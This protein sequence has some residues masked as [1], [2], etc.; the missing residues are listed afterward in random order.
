M[1]K[2]G[3]KRGRQSLVRLLYGVICI[4]LLVT[5]CSGGLI[6]YFNNEV[7]TQTNTLDEVADFQQSY[8]D[9]LSNI[10]EVSSL[11]LQLVSTGYRENQVSRMESLLVNSAEEVEGLRQRASDR[12]GIDHY[13][14]TIESAINAYSIQ[15]ET[16]FSS[17]FV[18]D[19]IEQIRTRIVPVVTRTEEQLI[20]VDERMQN[21]L[22]TEREEANLAL[23]E[24]MSMSQ[25]VTGIGLVIIVVIPFVT[26]VLFAQVFK[27][28]VRHI[29][30]RV[31]A[32]KGGEFGFH[33]V[34]NRR[35]ELAH[36]DA[37]LANMGR[38]LHHLLGE[39]D[40]ISNQVM[41]V[42]NGTA[43]KSAEQFKAM[44]AIQLTTDELLSGIKEQSDHT[45]SISA[46][47]EEVSAS[48]QDI[49]E[50]IAY[51]SEKMRALDQTSQEGL[52]TVKSL[53]DHMEELANKTVQT[54]TD[55]TTMQKQ[56][57]EMTSFLAGI[58]SI[59]DQTNL[60]AINASIEAA[61]AGSF[62]NS[63]AVVANEIRKLSKQASDFSDQTKQ[64]L[65]ALLVE[66]TEAVEGFNKFS[67]QTTVM[68]E[69]TSKTSSLF[70]TILDE[71][72]EVTRSQMESKEAVND[73]NH[74]LEG[75]VGDIGKLADS[76]TV[77]LEKSG[78]VR[79][80]VHDQTERQQA[81]ANEVGSLEETAGM[82][83]KHKKR[84][85]SMQA[86]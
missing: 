60:V 80:I 6:Y 51:M 84:A 38:E 28:G 70:R 74:A 59:A 23:Q 43:I 69:H 30:A 24:A 7:Q 49:Y 57:Q 67:E 86:S 52:V 8:N 16:Y 10:N 11:K 61:K 55:M 35:D 82:L 66:T 31:R 76:A 63:F 1:G 58:D 36:V 54:A 64:T 77:L 79:V 33:H 27:K 41:D 53:E 72:M 29:L 37:E 68:K 81:L 46:T 34:S 2:K 14:D 19:E 12:E 18:G 4:T 13:F 9:L 3:V 42:A 73:I 56:M 62:G 20:N 50:A 32:Y 21:Y 48:A 78:K 65:S 45:T 22:L 39:A 25:L 75:V 5:I 47:T 71:N 26:L 85:N 44:Q 15:Y 83:K 40:R 17:I